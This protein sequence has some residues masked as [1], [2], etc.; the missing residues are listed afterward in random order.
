MATITVNP[1][2]TLALNLDEGERMTY[3]SLPAGQLAEYITMWLKER[4]EEGWRTKIEKL[5][6]PQKEVLVGFLSDVA[7]LKKDKP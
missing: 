2:N 5:S 6:T 1:D 3:D 7:E 4:F